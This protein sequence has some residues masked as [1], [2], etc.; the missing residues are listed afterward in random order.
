MR[1]VLCLEMT[2]RFSQ[3]CGKN[4]EIRNSGTTVC[5]VR[6]YN[7]ALT[8]SCDPVKADELFEVP[9]HL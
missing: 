8:F 7:Q 3:C 5:R 6:S 2:H 9:I 1:F 4:V